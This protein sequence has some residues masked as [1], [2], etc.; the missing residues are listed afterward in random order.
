MKLI[1]RLI[2]GVIVVVVVVFA[3]ANRGP[4]TLSLWPLPF[5]DITVPLYA[6]VLAPM[7]LGLLLGVAASW[8]ARQRLRWRARASEKRAQ[9]AER[10]AA[11]AA[12]SAATASAGASAAALPAPRYRPA[13]NDE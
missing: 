7:A 13:L 8:F 11:S 10:S 5:Q 4:V 9:A 2:L 3:L 12:A 1:G 6:A